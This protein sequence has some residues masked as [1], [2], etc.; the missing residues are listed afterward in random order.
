MFIHLKFWDIQLMSKMTSM[1]STVLEYIT[2]SDLRSFVMF[3]D[4][5]FNFKRLLICLV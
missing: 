1:V 5:V 3:F 4:I 2:F